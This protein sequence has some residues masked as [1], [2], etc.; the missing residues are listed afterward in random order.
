MPAKPETQ[1]RYL[2]QER[3]KRILS[4]LVER[5]RGTVV[6]ISAELAV[7][8]M[9]VR[10]DLAELET[11]GKLRRVHGGAVLTETLNPPIMDPL[12]AH[13]AARLALH[14]ESKMRIA[15]QAAEVAGRYQSVAL[16]IGTTTLAM[17]EALVQHERL[18]I[19]TNS[20]RIAHEIGR[21]PQA[22]EV[23]L[24]GGKMRDDEMAIVGPSA[25]EQFQQFWF[26]IAFI[27]ASGITSQ[28]IYDSS[29]DETEMKRVLIRRSGFKVLLCD[30]AKFQHM[31]LVQVAEWQDIDLL[32][33]D[34]APPA[35]L[36]TALEL[37]N[38]QVMIAT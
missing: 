5:G 6:E 25:I 10:R 20:V 4:M 24:A 37:A 38:V 14:R 21:Y 31:S 22:P 27:S 23:Y 18:K 33:T 30:A 13:F 7:S 29:L 3:K 8:E 2:P 32:I 11:D 35:V 12:P 1:T 9:T 26:D 34:S 28:G 17:A 16:D 19:F 36:A 15:R